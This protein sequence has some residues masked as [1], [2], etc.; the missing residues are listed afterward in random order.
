MFPFGCH[1]RIARTLQ[2]GSGPA[3]L[4]GPVA[5]A[6]L[7][8]AL[9]PMAHATTVFTS[10]PDFLTTAAGNTALE[11][12]ESL[13]ATNSVNLSSISTASFSISTSPSVRLGVFSGAQ[14][15]GLHPTDG[16]RFVVWSAL[17]TVPEVT[18]AFA[19]PID[20]FGLTLTDALDL[21]ITSA[22]IRLRTSSG[23]ETVVASGALPSGNEKFIGVIASEPFVE[24][25]L[26]AAG[27]PTTGDGLGFDEVRFGNTV[28]AVAG[29]VSADCPDLPIGLTVSLALSSGGLVTTQTRPGFVITTDPDPNLSVTDTLFNDVHPT[30]GGKYV[31]WLVVA[32]ERVATVRFTHPITAFGLV[33]TDAL[34][35]GLAGAQV[36]LRTD[37]GDETVAASGALPSGS[38]RFVGL[39]A[40]APFTEITLTVTQVPSTGEGIALDELRFGTVGLAPTTTFFSDESA[41]VTATGPSLAMES[42]E[43]TPISGPVALPA[44]PGLV[45]VSIPAGRY[46]F[47]GVPVSDFPAVVSLQVPSGYAVLS[48]TGGQ[49][50]IPWASSRIADFALLC[51]V[52]CVSLLAI[53]PPGALVLPSDPG[54]CTRARGG[55]DLGLATVAGNCEAVSVSNDAPEVF[56]IGTTLVTWTA[57][58]AAHAPVTATQEITV[59][60]EQ[61]PTLDPPASLQVTSGPGIEP[62]ADV[63]V[64]VSTE[65]IGSATA[66]DNCP[67]VTV[68]LSGVPEGNLFPLGTTTLTWTA[69]DAA[70][71]HASATQEVTVACPTGAL[72]GSADLV[73]NGGTSAATDVTVRLLHEGT[74]FRT[75][76]TGPT[77]EYRFEDVR[78][79]TY[80]VDIDPPPGYA[81]TPDTRTQTLA[82]EELALEPFLF[83]CLLSDLTGQALGTCNGQTAGLQG[84]TVDVYGADE[85]GMDVLV[86]TTATDASGHFRFDD[87]AL[88]DYTVGFVLPLGYT[89]GL[90]SQDVTLTTPDGSFAVETFTLTCQTIAAEPRS[91]GYWKHQVNVYLTG[92][93]SAQETLADLLH[94]VEEMVVHFNQNLV[95]PVIVYVPGGGDINDK[96]LQLQQ[97]LTVNRGGT[98]LDRAKQQLLA[99]LL[100]VAAGKIGQ[101]EVISNDGATVAQAITHS[102]DLIVDG[103]TSTDET[104]KTICDIINNGQRVP[105]GMVPTST[106]LITYDRKPELPAPVRPTELALGPIAPNPATLDA[107][108]TFALPSDAPAVLEIH[109]PAGRLVARQQVGSRGVG[110]HTFRLDEV[111]RLRPGIYLVRLLQAGGVKRLRLAVLR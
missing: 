100:N 88:G 58:E 4:A 16:S 91:M 94:Y 110:I 96:L 106:R 86:A 67:G 99:L 12:F 92:K 70:G 18:F 32:N 89:T 37:S 11:S 60:D 76:T 105:A 71:H 109:D 3:R 20:A 54:S 47:E 101:T 35:G 23:V 53:T 78:L 41:F 63:L 57:S 33:L 59:I 7:L 50:T 83:T 13:V 44:T 90:G 49:A 9:A 48:P 68:S 102:H 24:V 69:T 52:P 22:Q 107:T 51:P 34:D 65:Q 103:L 84:V 64:A 81:V 87:L 28:A 27:L 15:S 8:A 108:L 111:A 80:T 56:P 30:H 79:G 6:V 85:E 1:S 5:A 21:G 39:I 14:P 17:P 31:W 93:G 95:N 29:T 10:K 38:E 61:I 72:V 82:G 75:T 45:S 62:C 55:V 36:R 42:F 19:Q 46:V 25:V 77:G 2:R 73:C 97:L 104:A 98:M 26:T 74:P 66:A 40:S 43:F